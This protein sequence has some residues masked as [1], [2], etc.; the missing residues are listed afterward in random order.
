VLNLA[1]ALLDAKDDEESYPGIFTST[2]GLLFFGT[3][4]RGAPGMTQ[5]E[6]L[7][8]ARQEYHDD[9][10]QG[11]N[12]QILKVGDAFLQ[13]IVDRF[14]KIRSGPNKTMVACFFELKSTDVGKIVG[15]QK[16][17]VR[18]ADYAEALNSY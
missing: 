16:R 6:M 1:K 18:R 13:D 7:D 11:E 15:G 9:E 2:T 4:F 3:P 8:A 10:I 12:L 14:G 17:I 5:S